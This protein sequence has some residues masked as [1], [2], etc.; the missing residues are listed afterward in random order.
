MRDVSAHD[1]GIDGCTVL[2]HLTPST[3]HRGFKWLP[4]I[5]GNYGGEAV[6]FESSSAEE[7]KLWLKVTEPND[8]NAGSVG[9]LSAGT[10]EATLHLTS[11]DAWKLADQLRW[12]VENHYHGDATPEWAV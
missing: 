2:D 3:T 12:L 11:E 9:G 5:P 6:V 1:C 10:H 7:P 4:P 8:L